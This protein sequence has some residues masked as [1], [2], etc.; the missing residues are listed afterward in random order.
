[1][2]TADSVVHLCRILP[3]YPGIM[4]P[5]KGGVGRKAG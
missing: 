5:A 1:M 4:G 3:A 2:P